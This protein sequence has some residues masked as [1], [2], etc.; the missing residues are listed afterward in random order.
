MAFACIGERPEAIARP[1]GPVASFTRWLRK[2]HTAHQRRANLVNLLAMD[3]DQLDDLGI[4][5]GD[6][7]D[8]LHDSSRKPGEALSARRAQRALAW[9]QR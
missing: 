2:L 7:R 4:S 5:R 8:A 6:I 1:V 9:P 3:V